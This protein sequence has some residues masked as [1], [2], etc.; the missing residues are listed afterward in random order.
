M[1]KKQISLLTMLS[2]AFILLFGNTA[3]AAPIFSSF[4]EFMIPQTGCVQFIGDTDI[5]LFSTEAKQQKPLTHQ[6]LLAIL[7]EFN[8]VKITMDSEFWNKEMFDITP[9]KLSVVN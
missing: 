2:L 8:D 3:V 4:D 9:G 1:K 6:K 7:I 5:A